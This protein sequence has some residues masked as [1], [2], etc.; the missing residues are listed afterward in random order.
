M[1]RLLVVAAFA[2]MVAVPIVIAR[3]ASPR[4][5]R[6]EPNV[7]KTLVPVPCTAGNDAH[8]RAI[9][10][11]EGW[12]P[13]DYVSYPGACTRLRFAFGPIPVKPGQNDVLIE[14]ITIEKPS[15]DGYI[16]RMTAD[17]VRPDGTVPPIEQIHLHHGT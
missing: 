6:P 4:P 7:A 5:P 12:G 17:L 10:A 14:P 9:F 13:P 2:A 11:R 1:R 15:Q 16:T 8:E 3:A